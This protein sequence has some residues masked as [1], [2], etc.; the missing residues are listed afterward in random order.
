MS[1]G[2]LREREGEGEVLGQHF[3]HPFILIAGRP[4]IIALVYDDGVERHLVGLYRGSLIKIGKN[5]TC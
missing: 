4:R 2:H 5:V 1:N 3:E